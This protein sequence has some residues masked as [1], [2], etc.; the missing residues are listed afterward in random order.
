MPV[1]IFFF[2]TLLIGL[3]SSEI[4]CAKRL[5]RLED[6]YGN[7][8]FSDQ[9]P[10]EQSNNRRALLSPRALVL[11]VTEK[12][13][14]KEQLE[15]DERLAELRKEEEKLIAKQKDNDRALLS[16]Y[17][18]EDEVRNALKVKLQEFENQN[19]MFEGT[20]YNLRQQLNNQQKAAA[21]MERNGQAV[22]SKLL[23]D[24]QSTQKQMEM[25]NK[26]MATAADKQNILKN[27]YIANI[28]RYLFLTQ[29]IKRSKPQAIIPSIQQA[30]TL[31][32]FHCEND[33]QCNKA[34]EVARQFV[35]IHSTTVPDVYN[36]KLIMNRPPA[37]DTDISLSLSRI[38]ITDNDYQLFLDI[39]CHNSVVGEELC[40]SQRIQDLRASFRSYVND[41]LS[42]STQ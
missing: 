4:V 5:Y 15:L 9:V 2:S 18:S 11:E 24:I 39:H 22:S 25:V 40:S 35:N 10:P 29:A 12:A 7:T 13:K 42:R 6:Q 1:R 37:V 31:G 19:R 34:W 28:E 38:S 26:S 30:N 14:T 23:D 16:T 32:L 36:E 17:H 3:L 27:E 33:H 41:T 21:A 8:V 20:L